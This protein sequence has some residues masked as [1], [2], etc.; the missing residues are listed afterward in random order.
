[1]DK[2]SEQSPIRILHVVGGMNRAGIETW[3]MHI[4]RHINRDRF[5]MDF[6]VHT[7]EPCA[8]DE[9]IRSL[10][11]R[12]IPCLERSKPWLYARNFQRILSEYGAYHIVH[13]HVH[14]FS[15]YVLYLAK[16]AGIPVLIAH[17]HLDSSSHETKATLIRRLYLALMKQWISHYATLGL[18]CSQ[19]GMADL[20]GSMWKT[21]P[22]WQ[23]LY[24]GID[25]NPFQESIDS[26]AVRHEFGIPEDAFVVGHV[27]RFYEQ[28]NHNFLMDIA[29]EVVKQE[30]KTRFLLVG[31]GPLL[32]SIKRKV[33]QL[34]LKDNVIF[35]GVRSDIPRLMLGAMDVFLFPSLYEGLG[36][37]LIE[38]QAAGL[39]C[40][41]SDVI[42]EEVD[43]V[44]PLIQR[45]SL[46]EPVSNWANIVIN[47]K[48]QHTNQLEAFTIIVNSFFNIKIS[49]KS[50]QKFYANELILK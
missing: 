24:C 50:L 3:L 21:D 48:T 2:A 43:V 36:L 39:P 38:A 16:K 46:K 8:Y 20:F 12:I 33:I 7:T 31:D 32:P 5:Q 40:I 6:L 26:M 34:G 4:L 13:S 44:K 10:G 29:A 35:A 19:Q 30:P 27:G 42:P 22:R 49:N 23:L 15:G 1:M 25:I 47:T 17:S 18:G 11:S 14:H 37:V 45:I 9:E 41:F 28:K